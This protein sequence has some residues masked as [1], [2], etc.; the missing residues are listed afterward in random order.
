MN[1]IEHMKIVESY[2]PGL[3]CYQHSLFL[4][5][6]FER[7]FRKQADVGRP[8]LLTVRRREIILTPSS[9]SFLSVIIT[10]NGII[11][12]PHKLKQSQMIK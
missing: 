3:C 12:S 2:C 5:G 1:R 6:V 9:R 4:A 7:V 11:I 10:D 8:L